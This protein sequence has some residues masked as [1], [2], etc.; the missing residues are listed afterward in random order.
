MLALDAYATRSR[1]HLR[2]ASLGRCL[3][4][5]G[6]AVEGGMAHWRISLQ[7]M[8]VGGC[9]L[10]FAKIQLLVSPIGQ[11]PYSESVGELSEKTEKLLFYPL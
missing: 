10:C 3:L 5:P 8:L 4:C 9:A 1:L 6:S 11:F 2:L 7:R